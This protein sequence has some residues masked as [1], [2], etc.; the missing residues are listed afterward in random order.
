MHI[1]GLGHIKGYK[2]DIV[3]KWN[4]ENIHRNVESFIYLHAAD[5]NH[6]PNFDTQTNVKWNE[7]FNCIIIG[8]IMS[9]LSSHREELQS[10][11][12]LKR[13]Q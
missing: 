8:R 11:D 1:L 7:P 4:G 13:L 10:I 9:N 6:A 5:D 2:Q 3:W 12:C